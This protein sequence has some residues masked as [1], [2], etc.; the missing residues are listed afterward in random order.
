MGNRGKGTKGK[1]SKR[2][3]GKKG[4]GKGHKASTKWGD[5]QAAAEHHDDEAPPAK[6]KRRSTQ[7]HILPSA[8]P[9]CMGLFRTCG[10]EYALAI[11]NDK[12]ACKVGFLCDIHHTAFLETSRMFFVGVNTVQYGQ[13]RNTLFKSARSLCGRVL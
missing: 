10:R 13:S 1:S 6:K 8:C 7:V 3:K 12:A 11:K 4:G 9:M 2:G 5:E